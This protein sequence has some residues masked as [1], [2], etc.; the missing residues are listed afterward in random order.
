MKDPELEAS[1]HRLAKS[2]A[3]V[4]PPDEIEAAVLAEFDRAHRRGGQVS[5]V[6]WGATAMALAASLV[7]G[8]VLL[9]PQPKAAPV[10]ESQTFLPIPYTPP[11]E[12]YERVTVVET[13][14]PVR[15][16]LAAGFQ[17]ETSDPGRQ[18][19]G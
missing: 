11:L 10:A 7:V 18:R 17:V 19:H 13:N 5:T 8:V 14:V 16:L 4:T 12:P 3:S 15:A 1:L 2:V 6:R 9:R